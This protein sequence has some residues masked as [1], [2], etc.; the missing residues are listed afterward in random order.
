MAAAALAV[1]LVAGSAA[2]QRNAALDRLESA[3]PSGW[4]LLATGSELVIRHDRPCYTVGAPR[5][6]AHGGGRTA[7]R[8]GPLV[9]IELRYRLEPRWNDAQLAAARATNDQL[10][11]ELRAAATRYA[12]DT[13]PW[14]KGKPAPATAA[15]RARLAGYDAAR[16]RVTA[17]MV[18]LPRCHLGDTS[19]FDGDDTYA[20]L[21]LDLDPPE[22]LV[23]ARRI[24]ALMAQYCAR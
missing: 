12:V 10:G 4:S 11:G 19:V 20:Q 14:S 24:V 23:E 5:A 13:I 1:A 18:V 17:R 22:V 9:T 3:L 16:A 21:S 15:E 7:A 2:A 8:S 6:D